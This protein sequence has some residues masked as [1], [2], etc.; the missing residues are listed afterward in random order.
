[1]GGG[2]RGDRPSLGPFFFTDLFNIF[3]L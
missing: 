1:M 2:Q 3:D